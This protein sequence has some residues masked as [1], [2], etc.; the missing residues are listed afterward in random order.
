MMYCVSHGKGNVSHFQE[1]M[2]A[3][4]QARN[5]QLNLYNV[6]KFLIGSYFTPKPHIKNRGLW[7]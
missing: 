4:F 2:S 7:T 1:K 6:P 5:T 3:N